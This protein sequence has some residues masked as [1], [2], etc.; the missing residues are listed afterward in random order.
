[1]RLR[2]WW[3]EGAVVAASLLAEQHFAAPIQGQAMNQSSDGSSEQQ[4]EESKLRAKA[5]RGIRLANLLVAEVGK[6][7]PEETPEQALL[8]VL[9]ERDELLEK[10]KVDGPVFE[11]GRTEGRSE[12]SVRLRK[13]VDP[14]DK[15]HWDLEGTLKEVERLRLTEQ[16]VLAPVEKALDEAGIPRGVPIPG[17]VSYAPADRM[18]ELV[19]QARE[20]NIHLKEDK[21]LADSLCALLAPFAGDGARNEGAVEC[22]ERLLQEVRA[23]RQGP[24]SAPLSTKSASA[25]GPTPH[26]DAEGRALEAVRAAGEAL[27]NACFRLAQALEPVAAVEAERSGRGPHPIEVIL[28]ARQ[29]VAT[30]GEALGL[31]VQSGLN[32]GVEVFH[33]QARLD[34]AAAHQATIIMG[35]G[36]PLGIR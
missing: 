13:I 30:A 5:D 14:Q 7:G 23:T 33:Q 4:S 15:N 10:A 17:G 2:T 27:N 36:G 24:S 26:T 28:R 3:L 32:L 35:A 25:Q 11:M 21:R 1:M 19:Y 16:R 8:R 6:G 18:R 29:E 20:E 12:V 9:K 31:L 34:R 22:L